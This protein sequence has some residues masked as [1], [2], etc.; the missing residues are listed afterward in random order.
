MVPSPTGMEA[1]SV[2][3]AP[4]YVRHRPERTL[5]YPLVEEHYPAF[6][7]HLAVQ[8]A[9]LPEYAQQELEEYIKCARLGHGFLRL[10]FDR[11]PAE[12]LV[13]SAGCRPRP[14]P[15]LPD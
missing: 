7:V 9:D 3:G 13:A 15:S 6:K 1:S 11:C 2:I 8:G 14:A 5:A 4:S 12:R 10:R